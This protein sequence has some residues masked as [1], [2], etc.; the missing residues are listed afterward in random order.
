[1][2]A[3]AG[4]DCTDAMSGRA[5]NSIPSNGSMPLIGRARSSSRARRHD[6]LAL[7]LVNNNISSLYRATI[8]SVPALGKHIR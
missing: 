7:E 4:P 8:H 5:S 6:I 2:P 1:M 3:Q